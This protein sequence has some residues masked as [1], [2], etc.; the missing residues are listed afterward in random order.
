MIHSDGIV[1]RIHQ[2]GFNSSKVELA[3][4]P[5]FRIVAHFRGDTR[6]VT[7]QGN[8]VRIGGQPMRIVLDVPHDI[9]IKE[10]DLILKLLP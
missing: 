6:P 1:G 10:D 3:T 7:F 8:G 4:N 5:N 9:N 2:A